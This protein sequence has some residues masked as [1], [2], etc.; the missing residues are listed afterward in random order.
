MVAGDSEVP[1]TDN[2]ILNETMRE[3]LRDPAAFEAR[4]GTERAQKLRYKIRERRKDAIEE[5]RYLHRHQEAWRREN[6][7]A[8]EFPTSEPHVDPIRPHV[9]LPTAETI[10]IPLHEDTVKAMEPVR[11]AL[12]DI[13]LDELIAEVDEIPAEFDSKQEFA[14]WIRDDPQ[15]FR[16]VYDEEKLPEYEE[17]WGDEF[18]T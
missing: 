10:D 7:T 18:V 14:E 3:Y 8:F 16:M 13:F 9:P 5:L 15:R 12:T 11:A 6:L 4:E 17:F 2:G 1:N